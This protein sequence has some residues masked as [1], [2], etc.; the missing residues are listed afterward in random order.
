MKNSV[1]SVGME[2]EGSFV[3]DKTR[4]QRERWLMNLAE[5]CD[6]HNFDIGED[7]S[8]AVYGS[9]DC[10]DIINGELR[11]WVEIENIDGLFEFVKECFNDSF[12]QNDSCGNHI[13][14]RFKDDYAALHVLS[15]PRSWEM[16]KME[17]E[18]YSQ[19]KSKKYKNRLTNHYCYLNENSFNSNWIETNRYSGLN[20]LSYFEQQRTLEIR[21]LPYVITGEEYEENAKWLLETIT[22]IVNSEFNITYEKE[23]KKE[24]YGK[25]AQR[26]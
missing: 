1:I 13:H 14:V 10:R 26:I 23:F 6:I 12:T 25:L 7:G 19:F 4:S 9:S 24:S 16:F 11:G 5:S 8:V 21:I 15:T 20:I 18:A 2:L 22:K 17:Y 3:G